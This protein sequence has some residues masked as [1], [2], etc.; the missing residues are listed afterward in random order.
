VTT[1][2]PQA[3][4]YCRLSL[5]RDGDTTKVDDQ[6]RICRE[7][8]ERLSWDVA[9]VYTDNSRSAWQKNRKRP[10]WDAMLDA[11][12]AGRVNAI[13]VY[14]GDRLVRQPRD[15][16]DLL[17]LAH[18]KGVRLA[19]PT[20]T[21]NLDNDDDQ[22][23]LGIEANMARRESANTSRRM[24]AGVERRRRSGLVTAGGRGGRLFGFATDGVTHVPAEADIVRG[25]F[26]R[27]LTGEGIRFIARELAAE[28]VTTT[29]G[30]PMHPLA[31]R[32]MV[33]SPRY[34][35][36]MPDGESAAAWEPVVDR[37]DWETANALMTGHAYVLAPGHNAR[38][39]LL[40]GIA[41]CG[42]CGHP[43]QV[44]AGYTSP[45]SGRKVAARYGCLVVD[46][47][48]V[49]RNVAHLDTYVA[50][51]TVARLS[52]PGNPA[53]HLPSSPGVAAEIRVLAEERAELEEMFTDHT[54]GR[55]HLLLGRLDSIDARLAQLR[56]LT[57]A[58]AAARLID[59][60]MGIGE[61]EF[62]GLPLSVRRAVVAG[63]W[64]IRVQPASRR[65]P[66]FDPADVK[67]TPR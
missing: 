11:V 29:A 38:K 25:V 59:R 46:C 66:G 47:R 10:G 60:H 64:E 15:L 65:G 9:E 57:A 30:K 49:Y 27:V 62:N 5:A 56:E 4:I 26:A 45:K 35:G 8:A 34:V 3:A 16:E 42:V 37:G 19:S 44:L 39:Y 41:R 61:D 13:V 18:A 67:L 24:K 6:E 52:H 17:D 12:K 28:G 50:T 40:S 58:D 53:G 1:K 55:A 14:H 33:A 32:R 31:V 23:I 22:F 48:K 36:L 20:G 7:L 2:A 51:R 43:M 63:C 21:R 54:K